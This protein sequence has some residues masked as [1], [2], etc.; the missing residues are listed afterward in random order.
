MSSSI[1]REAYG[2]PYTKKPNNSKICEIYITIME[3]E[4]KEA[5]TNVKNAVKGSLTIRSCPH[6]H[7]KCHQ[8]LTTVLVMFP[9]ESGDT[10]T[11]RPAKKSHFNSF[12]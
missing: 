8:V 12:T 2:N 5:Y 7:I 9:K 3:R 6:S 11:G 1:Q 4:H 10:Q